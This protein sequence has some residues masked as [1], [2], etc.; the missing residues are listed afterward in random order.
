ME[1]SKGYWW[2]DAD[3][4]AKV[5]G[6]KIVCVRQQTQRNGLGLIPDLL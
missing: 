2:N 1:M 4:T 3:G 6:Q 5:H